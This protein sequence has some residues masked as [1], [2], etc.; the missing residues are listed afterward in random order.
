MAMLTQNLLQEYYNQAVDVSVIIP[1]HNRISMLEDALAS[2]FLQDFD[3][4]VEIIVIDDNS[5][6]RTSEIISKKYPKVRLISLQ[7]NV[8]AYAARNKA[9]LEAKGKYIAFLDSDDLW[10]K[11][12]LKTQVTALEGKTRCFCISDLVVWNTTKNQKQIFVQKPNLEK[13]TSL[14]HHF[15]VASFIYTP[16]SV[17]IPR[18]A[19]DEVGLF[20]ETIRIGEDAALYERCIISGY[21]PIFT[22]I[23]LA[24][25]RKHSSEQLTN[26]KN[27]ENRKKHRFDRVNK[28]YPLIEKQFSIVP[29]QRIHAE[30]HADFASQYISK[31]YILHWLASSIASAHSASLKYTFFN[32]I[33]DMKELLH[34]QLIRYRKNT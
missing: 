19:F 27:L 16:S 18:K 2:V 26:A 28:L 21:Q 23:P 15:L 1:T 24:I 5:Q 31:N 14:I 8:G 34:R 12:Y 7:Q 6:D 32:M 25:K 9:L 29:L 17:V 22:E 30:I 10:E 13:Y 4:T 3:G 33:D 20:D 11:N